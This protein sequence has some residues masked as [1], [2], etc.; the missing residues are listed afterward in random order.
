MFCCRAGRASVK[1]EFFV[2]KYSH[3]T[4]VRP[5]P[6]SL[7]YVVC[8]GADCGAVQAASELRNR[9]FMC[10]IFGL[11]AR[12]SGECAGRDMTYGGAGSLHATD[13]SMHVPPWPGPGPSQ[14]FLFLIKLI[15]VVP[16]RWKTCQLC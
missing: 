8:G 5:G 15:G 10:W 13:Q 14:H 4:R 2:G 3:R 1:T 9:I 16:L 6:G 11:A 12:G 7:Y